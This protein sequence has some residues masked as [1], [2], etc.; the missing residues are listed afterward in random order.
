MGE[1]VIYK[2]TNMINGKSYIGKSKRIKRRFQEHVMGTVWRTSGQKSYISKAIGKYGIENFSFEILKECSCPEEM[3]V[4]E[5]EFI[6]YYNTLS[7]NG[8]NLR[9]EIDE[10][11]HVHEDTKK[12]LSIIGQGIR[13][14]KKE[15]INSQYIGVITTSSSKFRACVRINRRIKTKTYNSETEAAQ[16]YDKMVLF[17]YGVNA[18]INFEEKRQEYLKED[19]Q[20][21]YNLFIERAIKK[22]SKYKFVTQTTKNKWSIKLYIPKNRKNDIPS[23]EFG[24]FDKEEDAAEIADK[25]NFC[26][27][28]S[29]SYNFPEK[30]RTY[31]KQKLIDFFDSKKIIKTSKY[32]GVC[33]S[34]NGKN[35]RS[36]FYI[37]RKQIFVGDNF[38]TEEEAYNARTQAI[39]NHQD[40][41]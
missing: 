20:D 35:Y 23:I 7:P 17:L 31:D 25:F 15:N 40:F 34:K 14:A 41:S 39:K 2:F 1:Y 32:E 19:L 8:Y 22:K 29:N 27:G 9:I 4:K 12:K 37:N 10:K 26:F 16:A 11:N 3:N 30:T 33:K 21:F 38:K 5:A 6:N 28:L 18:R 13:H 24:T 36:Y